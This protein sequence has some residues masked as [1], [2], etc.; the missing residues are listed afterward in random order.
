MNIICAADEDTNLM[1][2]LLGIEGYVLPEND[3]DEFMEEFDELLKNQEIDFIIMP[4]KYL[5]RHKSYFQQIK[6]QKRP[7]IVEIPDIKNPLTAEYFNHH[8][9]QLIGLAIGE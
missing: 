4:E 7:I 8:I 2:G 9:K 6:I 5:I 3:P 1:F